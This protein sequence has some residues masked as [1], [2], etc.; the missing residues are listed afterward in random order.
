MTA[1]V[2]M[3]PLLPKLVSP[4][5]SELAVDEGDRSAARLKRERRG[6]ADNSGAKD[7]GVDFLRGH[8]RAR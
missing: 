3:M 2:W 7:D 4:A 5:T 8:M 6:D 1:S